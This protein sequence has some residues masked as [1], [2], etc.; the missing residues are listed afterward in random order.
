MRILCP[1][2]S[3]A[4]AATAFE[5]SSRASTAPGLIVDLLAVVDRRLVHPVA[6]RV[7]VASRKGRRYSHEELRVALAPTSLLVARS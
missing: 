4:G 2:D 5:S 6:T 1:T 7:R 3:S